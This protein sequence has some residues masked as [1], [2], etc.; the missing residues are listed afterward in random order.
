M[1]KNKAVR[2]QGALD[3]LKKVKFTEKGDRTQEEWQK[4]VDAEI[5]TLEKR[6]NV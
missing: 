5:E 6:L 2:R 4:R 1:K 3:R